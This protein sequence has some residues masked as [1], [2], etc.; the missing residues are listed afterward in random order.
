MFSIFGLLWLVFCAST[1]VL[2]DGPPGADDVVVIGDASLRQG[3][4]ITSILPL[5]DGRLLTAGQDGTMRL[6]DL[7]TGQELQR[8]VDEG[9]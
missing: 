2:A 8:Y 3:A 1:T 9:T 4:V 7:Q 6:W 5:P